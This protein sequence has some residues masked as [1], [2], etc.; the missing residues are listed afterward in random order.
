MVDPE[1]PL[2]Q[3]GPVEVVHGKDGAPLVLVA[4]ESEPL[5][6][7]IVVVSDEVDVDDLAVLREHAED[8]PLREFVGEAA[9]EDPCR[10]PVLVVPGGLGSSEAHV[11]LTIVHQ[12]HVLDVGERIHPGAVRYDKER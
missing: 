9:E 11:Q 7:S 3:P 1:G 4:E 10:V 5:A 6:I 12:V 2:A 8:V